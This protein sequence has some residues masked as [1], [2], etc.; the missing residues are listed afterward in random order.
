MIIIMGVVVFTAAL[1]S[2][3]FVRA[4]ASA[5]DGSYWADASKVTV[6]PT[7][8]VTNAVGSVSAIL[9]ITNAGPYT[10]WYAGCV[11][12]FDGRRW[13]NYPAG[14]VTVLTPSAS[15]LVPFSSASMVISVPS[16]QVRWRAELQLRDIHGTNTLARLICLWEEFAKREYK[17][18]V[19]YTQE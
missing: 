13:V 18:G 19:V 15:P 17:N 8:Y 3:F 16:S 2:W 4:T 12:T 7:G 14:D 9:A 1:G 6:T 10:F 11:D 5:A